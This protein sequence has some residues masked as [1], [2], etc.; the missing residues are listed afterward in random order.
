MKGGLG[1]FGAV[2][3][4]AT[5]AVVTEQD[6]EVVDGGDDEAEGDAAGHSTA[7][8]RI[9]GMLRAGH[10][11]VGKPRF[12]AEGGDMH[13][14]LPHAFVSSQILLRLIKKFGD[15][16]KGITS[17]AKPNMPVLTFASRVFDEE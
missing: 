16:F 11:V 13:I 3:E 4:S 5:K 12:E 7:G 10:G 1:A 17:Y 8:R 6:D 15:G 2:L 14:Y 9:V